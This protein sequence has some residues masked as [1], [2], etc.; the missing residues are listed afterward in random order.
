MGPGSSQRSLQEE[1]GRPESAVGNVVRA[2]RL[3]GR[4]E[5]AMSQGTD[6]ESSTETYTLPYVK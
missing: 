6:R 3:E 5:G 4:R 2:E 1:A